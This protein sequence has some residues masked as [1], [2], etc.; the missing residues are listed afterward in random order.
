MKDGVNVVCR[1]QADFDDTELPDFRDSELPPP[2]RSPV[3]PATGGSDHG[4]IY[5]C[6][7]RAYRE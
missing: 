3:S 2:P 1:M 6:P 7:V 5:P 4:L